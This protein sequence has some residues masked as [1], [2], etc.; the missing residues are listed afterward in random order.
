M[1]KHWIVVADRSKARIF[2]VDDP[3]G[4]LQ[5]VET[6][7]HPEG[8]DHARDVNADRQGRAFDSSGQGRHA[9]G[10]SVE[11]MEQDAIRFSK[12]VSEHLRA[13]CH[14]GRCNRLLLVAGPDFLGLLRKQLNIPPDVRISEIDKNV[15]RFDAREIR[16]HLPDRL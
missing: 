4:A 12:E 11:P 10:T 3:H 1:S 6:L 9:M 16:G 2:T 8:R 14:D 13:A 15:C 7:D 5:E